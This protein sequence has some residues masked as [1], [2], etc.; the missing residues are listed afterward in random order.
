V[1]VIGYMIVLYG[2]LADELIFE[3]PV[4]GFDLAGACM[5]F[6]VTVGVTIYKLKQKVDEKKQVK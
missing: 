1:A 6:T 4:T 2:F 5:I 3:S